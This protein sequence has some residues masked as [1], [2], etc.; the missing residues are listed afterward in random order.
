L[1][2]FFR[3]VVQFAEGQ[4]GALLAVTDQMVLHRRAPSFL[5]VEVCGGGGLLLQEV[6]MDY[7]VLSNEE[8]KKEKNNNKMGSQSVLEDDSQAYYERTV[9]DCQ[10]NKGRQTGMCTKPN[11]LLPDARGMTWFHV[12]TFAAAAAVALGGAD[13]LAGGGLGGALPFAH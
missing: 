13:F 8:K 5:A 6:D 7:G 10:K 9:L 2:V 1:P 3:H 12:Y 11:G 4:R